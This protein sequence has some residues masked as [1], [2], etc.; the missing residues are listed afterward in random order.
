VNVSFAPLRHDAADYLSE[1]VGIDYSYGGAFSEPKWF[2]VTA[3]DDE[4]HIA[5]VLACEFKTWFDVHFNTAITDQ[6]CMSR[7]L[8]RAVFA[9]LFTRAVRITANVDARNV[10]AIRQ[11]KRLG[12]VYEGFCRLGIE[13]TRDACVFGM[14]KDDCKFLAGYAGGTTILTMEPDYGRFTGRS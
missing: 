13:G 1:H 6:R 14:L 3:R 8:L 2:C 10:R 4:G 5:G 12:F 11:M 9:A 7:R